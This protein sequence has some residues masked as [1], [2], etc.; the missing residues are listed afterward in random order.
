MLLAIPLCLNLCLYTFP[1]LH[2]FLF[3]VCSPNPANCSTL[4]KSLYLFDSSA[5]H[6]PARCISDDRSDHKLMEGQYQ[7]IIADKTNKVP[8][9]AL[10]VVQAAMDS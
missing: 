2:V 7:C 8:P 5:V 6:I 9:E 4:L 3:T 10:Q 1:L